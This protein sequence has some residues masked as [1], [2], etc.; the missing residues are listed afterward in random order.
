MSTADRGAQSAR[1]RPAN[2]PTGL[3]LPLRPRRSVMMFH[4]T[5]LVRL[6][7]YF[8]LDSIDANDLHLV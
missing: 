4:A 5:R 2:L 7:G 3:K 6:R 8:T 1:L